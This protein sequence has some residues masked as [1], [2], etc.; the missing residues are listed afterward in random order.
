MRRLLVAVLAGALLAG[1][2]SSGS[3][4]RTGGATPSGLPT[5]AAG[6]SARIIAASAALSSAHLE[7]TLTLSGASAS[8]TGNEQL[9]ANSLQ[10]LDIT[11]NVP[12]VGAVRVVHTD[13][14]TYA[15]LPP[16]LNTSGKP[17]V[18]VTS[19]SSNPT[20]QLLAPYVGAAVAAVTPGE[21][22]KLVAGA[23]SV[24]VAGK[25]TV[26]GVQATH[27]AVKVDPAKLDTATRT[28][29]GDAGTKPLPLDLWVGQDGRPARASLGLPVAGQQV[30]IEV[31][32]TDY[33]KPVDISA[34]PADQIG[35]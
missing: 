33:D 35:D 29:L 22:G 27:Y 4:S 10:A 6:L 15:K 24:D 2:T 14:N 5:T 20:V 19:D 3:P 7:V 28:E 16:A 23:R 18:A 34:P 30:P 26:A 13:G 9:S 11:L 12:G 17:Y 25:Q 31:T 32:F 8:G 1:C 21:L